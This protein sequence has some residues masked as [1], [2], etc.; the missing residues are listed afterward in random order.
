MSEEETKYWA[1]WA[2]NDRK[3][4]LVP[5]EGRADIERM[6]KILDSVDSWSLPNST[7]AN[8]AAIKAE[9]TSK[10]EAKM[11]SF[12]WV[13]YV[14]I[15]ASLLLVISLI[16]L[17]QGILDDTYEAATVQGEQ[18]EIT[19]P[20]GTE[21]FL[22][23]KS[24]V[25]FSES[26]IGGNRAVVLK[27]EAHFKVTEGAPFVLKANDLELEVVSSEFNVF[28]REELV[29]V[30]CS[31]G[32]VVV[33]HEQNS[34]KLAP[35]E[36]CTYMRGAGFVKKNIEGATGNHWGDGRTKFDHVDLGHVMRAVE[37]RF[38][39]TTEIKES[40]DTS[41]RVFTGYIYHDDL[42]KS[43]QSVVV[44]LGLDYDLKKNR[45]KIY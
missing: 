16:G 13:K 37:A 8:L 25:V 5:D 24:S 31:E 20:D 38:G 10:P 11:V 1:E 3:N 18:K 22:N 29:V 40:T 23:N 7:D 45:V 6:S 35:G 36:R 33:S 28:A 44:P 14:A 19:L 43:I 4:E 42:E 39:V 12:G 41:D 15:A 17:N 30:D 32:I 26:F 27:G 9:T 34:M 2:E 21:V